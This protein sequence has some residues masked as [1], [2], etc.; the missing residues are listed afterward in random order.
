[1]TLTATAASGSTFA[2]WSGGGCSGTGPC[3]FNLAANTT[4]S[5][6]FVAMSSGPTESITNLVAA[7]LPSS[8]SVQVGTAATAFA[9][10]I[11]PS[12]ETALACSPALPPSLAA[13]INYSYQTT[14]PATNQT[15]GTMNTPVDMGPGALQTFVVSLTP[16]QAFAP[17]DVAFSFDCFNSAPATSLP[18]INTLLLS[19][20]LTPIPDIVALAATLTG[21]GIV[22]VAGAGGTGVFAVAS[23]NVGTGSQ[24]TVTADTGGAALPIA[25]TLCETNPASGDCL[26]PMGSMVTT[27][28]AAG[29]T[30]T[31]GIF[32]Q[33]G[34]VVAFSPGVNRIFVRF[35]DP[36]GV[37]RGSTSVAVRTQ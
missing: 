33:G 10:M 34:G 16:T 32:I 21:D 17:G 8:R 25:I 3:T 1:M 12:T 13:L 28:I 9:T 19:S 20:S 27:Q 7:V 30:P 22:N 36:G 35:S 6:S 5:A 18:G 23:V 14:D 26:G 29:A 37:I 24:I 15:T 2:G 31:F 4:V 11:N